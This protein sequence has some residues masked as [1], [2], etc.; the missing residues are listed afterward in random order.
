MGDSGEEEDDGEGGEDSADDAAW[1]EEEEEYTGDD[2]DDGEYGGTGSE[3]SKDESGSRYDS[4]VQSE[5]ELA[6]DLQSPRSIMGNMS[7]PMCKEFH[8]ALCE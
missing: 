7:L 6:T 4:G 3:D 5:A 1:D 8:E 2:D